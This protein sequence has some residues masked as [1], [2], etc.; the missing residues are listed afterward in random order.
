MNPGDEVYISGPITG[1]AEHN[2]RAFHAAEKL[3]LEQGYIP[4]SPLSLPESG[5][6]HPHEWYIRR[7]IPVMLGCSGVYMLEGWSRSEGASIEHRVAKAAG[8]KI[9]YEL[10]GEEA[11]GS[12]PQTW[13]DALDYILA[14]MREIMIARQAKYG[15]ENIRNQG[16]HGVLTRAV[17]DKLARIMRAL[18]GSVVGGRIEL[19][20]IVDE[21]AADTFEDGCV[22]AAN[23]VGPIALMVYRGWWDLP[24]RGA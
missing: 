13:D 8:L 16:L 5:G 6:Q 17:S 2:A 18:N 9:R 23:Y 24:R 4:V 21:E 1:F 14:E 19:D 11:N 3:L 7:D 20:P 12:E 22:D 15:P 10:P